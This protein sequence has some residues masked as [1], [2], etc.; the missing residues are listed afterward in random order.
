MKPS[1]ISD[2]DGVLRQD[3]KP[4]EP[5]VLQAIQ[6]VIE[7]EVDFSALSGG[8]IGHLKDLFKIPKITIFG[9]MGG[10][11]VISGNGLSDKVEIKVDE[12]KREEIE[13]FKKVIS[14]QSEDGLTEIKIDSFSM[15]VIVEGPRYTSICM[16]GGNP[17]HYPWRIPRIM[18]AAEEIN[19]LIR[20]YGFKLNCIPGKDENYDWLE[21]VSLTKVM[22][23]E[24][25]I[26]GKQKVYYIGDNNSDLQVMKKL[27]VIPVGLKNSISEIRDI[28]KKRGI[29]IDKPGPEGFI[30]FIKDFIL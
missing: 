28:A 29:Y 5:Q 30:Q 25:L 6:Q 18:E 4:I 8:P 16:L 15:S 3:K 10:V 23:V 11:K 27:P 1:I 26:G 22:S 19:G 2:V 20:D 13:E 21:I 7:N 12:Q 14:L 9:E 24:Q 17:P